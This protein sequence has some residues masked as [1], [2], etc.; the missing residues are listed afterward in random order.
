MT[1]SPLGSTLAVWSGVG[2][3]TVAIALPALC[4]A[5]SGPSQRPGTSLAVG[6]APSD[7]D[8]DDSDSDDSDDSDSYV[9]HNTGCDPGYP[10]G[11]CV[12]S[13]TQSENNTTSSG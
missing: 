1:Q 13:P 5:P 4:A 10:D 12:Q 11:V 2:V 8:S 6:V 7:S 3:L 9:Q